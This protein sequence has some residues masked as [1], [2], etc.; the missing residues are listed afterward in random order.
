MIKIFLT[1]LFLCTGFIA[2]KK[3]SYKQ[4]E[5]KFYLQVP[6]LENNNTYLVAS[7]DNTGLNISFIK[8]LWN[9]KHYSGNEFIIEA[10][11][12]SA[13]ITDQNGFLAL[14][15]LGSSPYNGQI[16]NL[17]A[18]ASDSKLVSFQSVSNSNKEV[19]L[20]YCYKASETFEYNPTME[21]NDSCHAYDLPFTNQA[22]TCYC[23]K[24]FKMQ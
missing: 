6:L 16:F 5:G 3:D 24:Q 14:M 19:T 12:D 9:F 8:Y 13:V 11:N 17:V 1:F 4:Y 2:C 15:P 23:V 7:S 10:N 18:S 20:S 21:Y 22:D